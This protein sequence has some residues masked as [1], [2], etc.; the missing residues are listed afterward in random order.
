MI[1]KI[2]VGMMTL[3]F[4]AAIA[5]AQTKIENAPIK[6]TPIDGKAM[7]ASYCAACHGKDAR[8]GGPAA[9][10]L[11][12][13]PPDLTTITARSGGSFPEVKIRRII[14]GAD[15]VQSH[16]NREMPMWGDLFKSL[17]RDMAQI[18]ISALVDY[19]KSIQKK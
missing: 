14:E 4:A 5:Q 9:P 18:R 6:Q 10:A 8:G 12:N 19:V 15:E 17:D 7:F 1:R 2:L 3:T 16:G 13:A 11:K